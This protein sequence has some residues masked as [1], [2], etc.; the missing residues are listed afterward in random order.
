MT[1]CLPCTAGYFCDDRITI[2]ACEDNEYSPAESD[3]CY[4]CPA[5]YSCDRTS[6][7]Q[8][9]TGEYSYAGEI[10]CNICKA[11]Y[12]C[13]FM[14]RAPLLC[15]PGWWSLPGET[16]CTECQANT[17]CPDPSGYP[18][19]C[20]YGTWSDPGAISCESLPGGMSIDLSSYPPSMVNCSNESP[21]QITNQ[22]GTACISCPKGYTCP[23]F[24]FAEMLPCSP[25]YYSLVDEMEC[26]VC[27][28]GSYC[29]RTDES[30]VPVDDY[31]YAD[32]GFT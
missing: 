31:S 14:D 8:C 13:P 25:G 7:N 32:I 10:N 24:T 20:E 12:E 27:P 17:K 18:V 4:I 19:N 29:P 22:D 26:T 16:E 11:G 5:G 9:V 28:P 23:M 30:P 21:P 1:A 6:K 15:Q 2:T 3:T